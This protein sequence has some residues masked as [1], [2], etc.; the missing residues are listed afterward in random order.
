LVASIAQQA[1]CG[2][3]LAALAD[4]SV[5]IEDMEA[6]IVAATELLRIVTELDS[7][8]TQRCTCLLAVMLCA[9]CAMRCCYHS[10]C[11]LR[12]TCVL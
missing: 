9:A 11:G 8:H 2:V 7:L 4:L 12:T 5:A 3:L 10:C 6:M 1:F